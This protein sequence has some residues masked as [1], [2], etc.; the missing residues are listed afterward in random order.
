[1][2]SLPRNGS[3]GCDLVDERFVVEQV[4]QVLRLVASRS[5]VASTRY[6]PGA[7]AP[8]RTRAQRFARR[9]RRTRRI[10]RCARDVDDRRGKRAR[11]RLARRQIADEIAAAEVGLGGGP[12]HL[13]TRTD[14]ALSAASSATIDSSGGAIRYAI[15]APTAI[16]ASRDK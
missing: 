9:A 15:G 11:R 2:S 13:A 3:R 10:R 14:A 16:P 8:A 1:M 12:N 4:R 7:L 6:F 5:P